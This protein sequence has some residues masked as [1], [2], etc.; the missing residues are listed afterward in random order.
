MITPQAWLWI[1]WYFWPSSFLQSFCLFI[2]LTLK[3]HLW[4]WTNFTLSALKSRWDQFIWFRFISIRALL[5]LLRKW[6]IRFTNF[7]FLFW[8]CWLM[9]RILLLHKTRSICIK[10]YSCIMHPP[11]T[12]FTIGWFIRFCALVL[13]LSFC[14][15]RKLWLDSNIW[16]YLYIL[17]ARGFTNFWYSWCSSFLLAFLP[18][19][20]FIP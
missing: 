9:P 10:S 15:I 6:R 17:V 1:F 11:N 18:R 19:L 7:L 14:F 3:S 20:I 16:I 5:V 4:S 8:L 12:T 2:L 13:C